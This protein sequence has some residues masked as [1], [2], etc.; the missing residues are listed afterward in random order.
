MTLRSK[1]LTM[2]IVIG[3]LV[4]I[5]MGIWMVVEF[6]RK[7]MDVV[8]TNINSQLE[9]LDFSISSFILEI[10]NDLHALAENDLVKTRDDEDFTSFLEANEDTF[11]YNIGDLEQS[12]IEILNDYRITHEYVN[13]V[14][15][16]RENGSFVRSHP[17]N[18]PTQYDPR[19]RP[20]Y[21]IAYEQPGEILIT[22]PYQSVTA[23]DVNIGIVTALQEDDSDVYGVLGIDVTLVNLTDFISGF[24]VSYSGHF[25]LVHENGSILAF[26][27]QDVLNTNV[28]SLLGDSAEDF[29]TTDQGMVTGGDDYYFIHTSPELGWKIAAII[30]IS[31]IR[32]EVQNLAYY[33]PLTS[34]FF[35]ILLFGLLS[36]VGLSEFVTKP[37]IK[38]S[39]VTRNVAKSGQLDQLV[40]IQSR[41]EIGELGVSFNQMISA[42]KQIEDA[43]QQE[44]DLARAFGE[45]VSLLGTSLDIEKVLDRIL[46]QVSRV[47]PN[48]A[49]NIMLIK[50]DIA[51]I[52]RSRGYE[53]L[54]LEKVLP[55]KSF[56]IKKYPNL[57]QMFEDQQPII[58]PDTSHSSKW[59]KVK[60][61]ED[62]RSY[63]GAPII[64]RGSVIG[65]L[66]IDSFTRN[67]YSKTHF[68]ALETFAK[69]AAIAIDNAQLHEQVR[70]HAQDLKDRVERATREINRRADELEALYR[71]G[72][73]I[74][75]TLELEGMLQ[76]IA[77]N[78]AEIVEADGSII[79]LI[80]P[81]NN[82]FIK[83][84]TSG[85]SEIKLA[86]YSYK[87]FQESID[88]WVYREK[89]PVMLKN[90]Q[91][92]K[93]ISGKALDRVI[94]NKYK[95]VIA[96][97]LEIGGEILGTISV[98]RN[99]GK[100]PFDI[101][102]LSLIIM[103]AAQ[104]T[105][106]IQNAIL[107]E[108]AQEA[109]RM[110]SA[111][112]ASMS[113]ELRTPLNSIIG[114]TG[115]LL[116]GLVG[117][118]NGEQSK[119]MHMVQNSANHLLDLIND[120]L[121][122]SKI[123]AGQLTI[124]REQFNLRDAI[125]RVINLVTP[126][127]DKKGLKIISR[128]GPAVGQINSDN[129]RVEQILI[130]LINNAIKFT[131]KGEIRVECDVENQRVNIQIADT[132]IGIKDEDI[133]LL[134]KPFQQVDTGLSR[135]YE[136]TGLGLAICKRLVNKLGGDIWVESEWGMGSKF[137]FTLPVNNLEEINE[138]K[139]TGN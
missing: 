52:A 14:Y 13:S 15:M 88:G 64:V 10:K 129:R 70:D 85:Y 20:W 8:Q 45:A 79:Q 46:D 112:L 115:I 126:M 37:L 93:R 1:L 33:P 9:L 3:T 123:E 18:Q 133:K 43:L 47:I 59:V 2:V 30:P 77:D 34:L 42:R 53:K 100:K 61:Y 87:E 76:I 96:A 4:L 56:E 50:A 75:S 38:L 74:T 111:F 132:G 104:A 91:K 28:E 121:D 5:L 105:V 63:A 128:I 7:Q 119:Q 86:D 137:S 39:D 40:E 117:D 11:E 94:E 136:G 125:E 22:E 90:I 62:L 73:D 16:G 80:N 19:D 108:Q 97:P 92:D 66:N 58:I 60:G 95:S 69:H 116:Q 99:K 54:K 102:N 82:W 48:D 17:R 138:E 36:V 67:F 24:N 124:N 83:I 134:F 106:A 23:K 127:I 72:K 12:I 21:I 25:L 55:N 113:H 71:I 35:T 32:K 44:R 114:F 81:E 98:I 65:F 27:D 122:I 101:D 109:D 120:I 139:S 49:V 41:D 29:M 31:V 6:N 51:N 110:K 131:E 135:E 57:K 26:Q 89:I 84:V 68:D 130:N 118:L 103:L 78:A 107:Y